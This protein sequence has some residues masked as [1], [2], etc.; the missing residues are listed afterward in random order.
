MGWYEFLTY[1][2]NYF[3]MLAIRAGYLLLETFRFCGGRPGTEWL[4]GVGLLNAIVILKSGAVGSD[5]RMLVR[6]VVYQG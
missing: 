3:I 2:L 4:L 1:I 6:G 5:E